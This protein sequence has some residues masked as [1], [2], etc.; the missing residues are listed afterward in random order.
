MYP[1]KFGDCTKTAAV[2]SDDKDLICSIELAW[3]SEIFDDF[4]NV[5]TTL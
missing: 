3:N 4:K 1:K 5:L 2:F